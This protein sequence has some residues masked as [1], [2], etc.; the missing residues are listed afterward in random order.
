VGR[1][2]RKTAKAARENGLPKGSV[3]ATND[4]DRAAEILRVIIE[5]GDVVLIKGSRFLG[6]ERLVD[7]VA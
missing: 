5:P 6:L 2:A 4:V 7:M 1:R 3:F